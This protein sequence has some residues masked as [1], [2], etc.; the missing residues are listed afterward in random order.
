[1]PRLLAQNTIDIRGNLDSLAG[2]GGP[3]VQYDLGRIIGSFIGVALIVGA[4]ATLGYMIL[5]GLNWIMAGGDTGKIT[6]ARDKFI[7]SIV[8]LA[9]LAATWA[10]F[11][12]IQFFFGINLTSGAGL[13]IPSSGGN[14]GESA[15]GN[16][17]AQIC[18]K[19]QTVTTSSGNYCIN[20]AKAN[21]KCYGPG[22]GTSKY[23]Y[24]HWEPCSCEG[25]A[26]NQRAG[27]TFNC[28]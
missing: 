20:G 18:E 17:A 10:L 12:I 7:Q 8:G 23:S 5:A 16:A 11:L 14:G 15:G 21:L 26:A 25:G 13:N 19:N 2:N 28:T 1:M 24:N 22:E 9:V 3:V 6:K 27:L 4:I